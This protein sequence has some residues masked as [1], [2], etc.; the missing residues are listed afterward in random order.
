MS[1][2]KN[3]TYF[4]LNKKTEKQKWL[5]K[6]RII[7]ELLSVI[8]KPE[9]KESRQYAKNLAT[10]FYLDSVIVSKKDGSILMNTEDGDAFEKMVKASSMYEYVNSEFPSTKMMMIKDKNKYTIIYTEGDLIYMFKTS[11]EVSSI[12]AKHI[13]KQLNQAVT[14]YKLR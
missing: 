8:Q 6:V 14:D 11:G 1:F 7:N 9:A 13:A 12:E 5:D 10:D 2:F 4:I 3:A